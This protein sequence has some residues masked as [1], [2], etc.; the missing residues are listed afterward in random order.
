MVVSSINIYPEKIGPLPSAVAVVVLTFAAGLATATILECLARLGAGIKTDQP[1][2]GATDPVIERSLESIND[3]L[4]R[5]EVVLPAAIADSLV[6]VLPAPIETGGS[7]T[8]VEEHLAAMIKLLEEMKEVSMLDEGQ[9][10]A[11]RQQ[12]VTRRK[13]S[14]LDEVDKLIAD[15]AW[16]EADALLHLL[17]SLTPGDAEVL[18]R[19]TRMDES[20]N[21]Q[22]A[23]DWEQL[24]RQVEDQMALG[25]FND[26]LAQCDTF[27][28]NYPAHQ[29]GIDLTDRVRREAEVYID[30]AVTR[31]FEEIK[32][33]VESRQW[34]SAL[35]GTQKFLERFPDHPRSDKIRQQVRVIQKNAEVEERQEQEEQLTQLIKSRRYG[36]AL[37]VAEDLLARFPESPQ[38]GRM[39]EL[40][41]RLREKAAE[42]GD[43]V[44]S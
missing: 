42:A 3:S 28:Q 29:P 6:A 17:D 38:A 22:L 36:E 30:R 31:A 12:I 24:S 20:R 21:A 37:G 33:A 11:R 23:S 9:R 19:R 8:V 39:V 34:R 18:A 27:R 44:A 40:L 2:A 32:A 13:A 43:V 1:A 7:S 4:A 15:R 14:R 26:A 25:R 35:L 41:P 16:Q 10:Q 5:L